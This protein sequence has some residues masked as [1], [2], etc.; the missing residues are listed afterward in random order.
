MQEKFE[1]DLNQLKRRQEGVISDEESALEKWL[2]TQL[3]DFEKEL[4]Y[5][6]VD[7]RRRIE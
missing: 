7:I 2:K 5:Q 4:S 6:E 3:I 1:R